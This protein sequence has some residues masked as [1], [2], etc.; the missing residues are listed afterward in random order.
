MLLNIGQLKKDPGDSEAFDFL[1]SALPDETECETLS[2][3]RVIGTVTF[4]G[5]QFLLSGSLKARVSM[6]CSR[7]LA[8]VEQ[9]FSAEFAEEYDAREYPDEDAIMDVGEI[10]AQVWSASIPMR[11]L[12]DEQCEGLCPQCGKNL[13]EGPCDCSEQEIDARLEALRG[14]LDGGS[15]S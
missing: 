1:V 10:A 3:I 7:C 15:E 8:P 14:F 4:G 5:N 11:V 12:C 13:N 6:P 2:P 9:E